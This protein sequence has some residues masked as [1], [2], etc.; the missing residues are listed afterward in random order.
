M[1]EN[2]GNISSLVFLYQKKSLLRD[3]LITYCIR[4]LRFLRN[5]AVVLTYDRLFTNFSLRE[6]TRVS[7]RVLE[8]ISSTSLEERLLITHKELLAGFT[9]FTDGETNHRN[10]NK[11]RNFW[12][13]L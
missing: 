4:E 13:I 9:F 8:F 2:P 1:S 6:I 12:R 11:N 5:C 10:R 3:F 7:L